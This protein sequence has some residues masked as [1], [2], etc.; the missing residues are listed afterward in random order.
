[1]AE[2]WKASY[3]KRGHA[4]NKPIEATEEHKS[5]AKVLGSGDTMEIEDDEVTV[6]L[7]S[8]R[9]ASETAVTAGEPTSAAAGSAEATK[10]QRV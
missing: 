4:K 1:M 6:V 5:E 9:L 7:P 3:L 10:R 8:K 2:G